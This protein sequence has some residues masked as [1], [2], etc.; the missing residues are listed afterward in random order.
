MGN[1]SG[2]GPLR[3]LFK[4][5]ILPHLMN[6]LFILTRSIRPRRRTRLTSLIVRGVVLPRRRLMTLIRFVVIVIILPFRER[7]L[8]L[9]RGNSR[10]PL[11]RCRRGRRPSQRVELPLIWRLEYCLARLLVKGREGSVA[12]ELI[13]LKWDSR[14]VVYFLANNNAGRK[15]NTHEEVTDIARFA[16]GFGR[17]RRGVT[18]DRSRGLGIISG[19]GLLVYCCLRLR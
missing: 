4:V 6:L 15:G 17:S 13:F 3:F 2:F 14:S 1:V 16:C 19:Y 5:L 18:G 7:E 9:F 10:L 8:L 12:R 11:L